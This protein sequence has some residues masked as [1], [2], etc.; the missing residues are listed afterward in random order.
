MKITL[1]HDT[2][3]VFGHIDYVGP[4]E[5]LKEKNMILNKKFFIKAVNW[6]K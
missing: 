4:K 6:E 1:Q 3:N 2:V 5:V